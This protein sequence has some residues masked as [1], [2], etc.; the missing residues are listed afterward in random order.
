MPWAMWDASDGEQMVSTI[1][2]DINSG[3]P[4]MRTV[5]DLSMNSG[6]VKGAPA[7]WLGKHND[8]VSHVNPFTDG[9]KAGYWSDGPNEVRVSTGTHDF[10][11][12]SD[13]GITFWNAIQ[14]YAYRTQFAGNNYTDAGTDG[15]DIQIRFHSNNFSLF[16]SE[17]DAKVG[18]FTTAGIT[19]N[20]NLKTDYNG[21]GTTMIFRLPDLY[22]LTSY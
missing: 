15:I 11:D 10:K 22:F 8:V 13:P 19:W 3:M 1:S 9:G 4:R 21:N 20:I 6:M 5:T 2:E 12:H 7:I 17:L 14:L 16:Q 18:T